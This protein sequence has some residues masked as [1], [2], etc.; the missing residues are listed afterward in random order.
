MV[1]W[2]ECV[3]IVWGWNGAIIFLFTKC[4]NVEIS[5]WCNGGMVKFS[6]DESFLK[7][8]FPSM[9]KWWNGDENQ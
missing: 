7:D 2:L 6:N 1:G 9:A 5:I 3:N 4:W 8:T